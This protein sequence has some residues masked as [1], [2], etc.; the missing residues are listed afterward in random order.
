MLPTSAE[1]LLADVTV[2]RH[3][4]YGIVAANPKNLAAG[5]WMLER[6]DFRPVLGE[7]TLYALTDQQRDG[8]GRA[9]RAV[10]LL[11]NAGFRVDTDAVFNPSLLP[12]T[13]PVPS[14][15]PHAEPD[16]AFAEHPRLGIVA[17]IDSRAS[18]L[19]GLALVEHGW[20]HDHRLDIYTLPATTS[21]D[22]ALGKVADATLA[23]HRSGVQ[24]AV[25]PRL[26]Q[27]A[28]ARHRPAP[29]S[30][31][32]RIQGAGRSSPIRA[33]A[34]AAS[35]T[36]ASLPGKAPV[37]SPATSVSAARPVDPRIAFSRNR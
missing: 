27:D 11:R 31:L 3:P 33:A 1:E 20:R 12:G 4:D 9:T 30:P 21:R 26:A 2:G 18:G 28:A 22:E 32:D 14:R 8:Q 29:A 7:P 5:T 24:V 37:P 17:A 36:L 15:A 35:P 25:Q 23:L 10:A 16:V 13:E 34:L 6:L 19:T